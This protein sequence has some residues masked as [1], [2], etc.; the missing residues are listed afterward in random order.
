[1][2]RTLT[3]IG[4]ILF[5]FSQ[6]TIS[7]DWAP[8][9][10]EWYYDYAAFQVTG[11]IKI[12][13]SGDTVIDGQLCKTL[14]KTG[15]TYDYETEIYETGF[16][17]N[18]Y[19]WS[20]TDKVYIYKNGQFY[21]LYDFSAQ[22]GDSW[23]IPAT[24]LG[25][26]DTIGTMVVDS[27]GSIVINN[28]SLRVIYCNPDE[29]SHWFL[30]SVIIEKIGPVD[31]YMLPNM[32]NNCGVADYF[33]GGPLRCYSDDVLGLYSTGISPECD[34]ILSVENSE[35]SNDLIKVFPNPARDYV[36]FETKEVPFDSKIIIMNIFGQEAETL[37]IKSKKTVLD[38]RGFNEGVYLYRVEIEGKVF[39]GKI[40]IN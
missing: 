21:T 7:Q 14:A 38:A 3:I 19:T 15:F 31:S 9:G 4:L 6:N 33:V 28:I 2:K 29:S 22:A 1:M 18:E 20:D 36:V 27:T 32:T 8:E 30:G 37:Y 26:C 25:F 11:Y 16:I 34:Y 23:I 5:F 24:F 12:V 17:G 39:N 35:I 13:S 10:A 40:S